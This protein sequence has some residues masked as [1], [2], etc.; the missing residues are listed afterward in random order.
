MDLPKIEIVT[1]EDN[2]EEEVSTSIH[3]LDTYEDWNVPFKSKEQVKQGAARSKVNRQKIVLDE[4]TNMLE[5]LNDL[6]KN[7]K[8]IAE[9]YLAAEEENIEIIEKNTQKNIFDF[10]KHKLL[11]VFACIAV[12]LVLINLVLLRGKLSSRIK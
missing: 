12:I 4:N 8:K 6:E 7:S 10:K 3:P 1:L 9:E 5:L 2:N 11:I